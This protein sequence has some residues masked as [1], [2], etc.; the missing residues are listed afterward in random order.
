MNSLNDNQLAAVANRAQFEMIDPNGSVE[1]IDN[2]RILNP[3]ATIPRFSQ[4]N[5]NANGRMSDMWIED[6]S[7]LRIQNVRLGYQLPRSLI[8]KIRMRHAQVY[9]NVQNAYTFTDYSGYDPE[10][11]AFNQSALEQNVDMGRIPTPRIYT[12]GLSFGF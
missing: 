11:G 4:L 8:S 12:A 9:V 2:Y 5:V 10:I 6:G 3:N 1:D 7:Y